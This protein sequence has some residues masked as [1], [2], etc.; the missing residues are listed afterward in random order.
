[1]LMGGEKVSI[2]GRHE[3]NAS[4]IK[5]RSKRTAKIEI[6]DPILAKRL[7]PI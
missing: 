3:V 4:H 2:T 5:N 6:I 7:K 1:M